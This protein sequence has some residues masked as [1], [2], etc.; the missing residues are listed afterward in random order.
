[1][2]HVN[3]PALL[4]SGVLVTLFGALFVYASI[5]P[6]PDKVPGPFDRSRFM[7]TE[8]SAIRAILPDPESARFRNNTVSAEV[9]V[10]CGE[11]NVRNSTNGYV[12]FK[13]FVSGPEIRKIEAANGV[14]DRKFE[15]AFGP[16]E[17]DRLWSSHCT[18]A[19]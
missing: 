9:P 18:R 19:R 6:P 15:Y 7:A 12:G 16:D 2:H 17:M 3:K 8:E 11:I 14:E 1:M 5:V 13:R 4:V 10:V